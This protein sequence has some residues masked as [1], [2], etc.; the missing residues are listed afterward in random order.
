VLAGAGWALLVVAA[1]TPRLH[2]LLIAAVFLL[3]AALRRPRGHR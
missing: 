1:N 2:F 3:L